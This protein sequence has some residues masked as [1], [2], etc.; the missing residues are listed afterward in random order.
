MKPINNAL[1]GLSADALAKPRGDKDARLEIRITKAELTEIKATAD[2][3]GLTV[4]E[5][6]LQLH[7]HAVKKL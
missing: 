1:S 4:T 3:L 7:R 5:Y 2:K 6:L